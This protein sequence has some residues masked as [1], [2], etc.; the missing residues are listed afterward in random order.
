[1]KHLTEKVLNT[2]E[3]VENVVM[4]SEPSPLGLQLNEYP[5]PQTLDLRRRFEEVGARAQA[6]G[7]AP[8]Q[9]QGPGDAGP[10][11]FAAS[12]RGCLPVQQNVV[13]FIRYVLRARAAIEN[14]RP[15]LV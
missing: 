5:K 10:R 9:R 13:L 1:M 8:E 4:I 12:T 14:Q 2:E 11:E 6:S 3:K 7:D 15:A